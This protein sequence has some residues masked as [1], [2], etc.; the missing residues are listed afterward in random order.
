MPA[1]SAF[2]PPLVLR[3]TLTHPLRL[4]LRPQPGLALPDR[5]HKSHNSDVAT[6]SEPNHRHDGSLGK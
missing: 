1:S 2:V 3:I 5:S 6:G 4:A